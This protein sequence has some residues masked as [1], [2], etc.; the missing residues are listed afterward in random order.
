VKNAALLV[1][2]SLGCSPSGAPPTTQATRSPAPTTPAPDAQCAKACTH[3]ADLWIPDLE[4]ARY[5]GMADVRAGRDDIIASCSARCDFD[6]ACV[7]RATKSLGLYD[8]QRKGVPSPF[9]AAVAAAFPLVR[10]MKAPRT[11]YKIFVPSAGKAPTIEAPEGMTTRLDHGWHLD[12]SGDVLSPLTFKVAS[13][14]RPLGTV[15]ALR[16]LYSPGSDERDLSTAEANGGARLTT[17]GRGLT[18]IST[19]VYVPFDKTSGLLCEGHA[20]ALSGFDDETEAARFVEAVCGS[21]LY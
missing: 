8:C 20:T 6:Y 15:Q 1:V 14:Y 5:T 17:I 16:D 18:M 4:Q 7:L 12:A 3:A 2:A 10:Y 9:M 19:L 13:A 11:R 21:I